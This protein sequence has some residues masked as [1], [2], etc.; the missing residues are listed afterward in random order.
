VAPAMLGHQLLLQR[1]VVSGLVSLIR[2]QHLTALAEWEAR[3]GNLG[4]SPS[5]R[6]VPG[7]VAAILQEAILHAQ[8]AMLR[9]TYQVP[10]SHL[11]AHLINKY[12]HYS[13]FCVIEQKS[14]WLC[15]R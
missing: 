7:C 10:P 13:R 14:H 12:G 6:T 8:P 11:C 3:T 1:G 4:H 15:S 9:D 5:G 2:P